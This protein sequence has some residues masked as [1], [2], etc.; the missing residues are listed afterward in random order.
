M[1]QPT[2][3]PVDPS[4][5]RE[6][7]PPRRGRIGWIVACSLG[8]GVVAALLLVLVV[9]PGAPEHVVTGGTLLGFGAGWALLA[10]LSQRWSDQPQRWALVPAGTLGVSGA[11]LLLLAPGARGM[12]ALGWG[13][14][15]VL[16]GLAV[17]VLV[18]ARRSLA[19]RTR[20]WLVYPVCAVTALAAVAGIVETVRS[21]AAP[22]MPAAGRTYDVAG[23]QLYLECSG[24][25]SPTVVLSSGFGQ[26]SPGWAW[27]APAVAQDT[28][29]CTHD[30]AGTGWSDP[31]G[32]PQDGVEV[33]AD[34]HML[35]AAAGV[36]GPYVL[37]GHS[38]GGVHDLV[39]ADRYP[40]DVAGMVLLDSS[41]P[42]QFALPG[43]ADSYGTWR[44]ASAL[45]PPLARLGLGRAAFGT[46]FG[47]LPP[48][49]R[50]RERALASS[51]RDLRGQRDEWSRLPDVFAQAQALTGLGDEPL[52]VLTAGRGLD[53]HW[54]A[55]QER[56][57]A[58]SDDS[59]HRVLDDAS[60][61][62]L[63]HDRETATADSAQAIRDVV[64]AVRSGAPLR[65]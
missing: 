33:A 16:L 1:A 48:D 7:R 42:E 53:P 56:L 24:T 45:L 40:S 5:R 6:V 59:V 62:S 10:L 41:T 4:P 34:L 32:H 15:P 18:Q 65:P 2:A 37:V 9:A 57:A 52:V 20:A 39:F 28:R 64:A 54:A 60:H 38:I 22:G 43:Y 51:A 44:R 19:S 47:E 29:V 25:G 58:L 30:R 27:V 31:A 50:D 36:P 14:P 46:G 13:W 23:R 8:A 3:T 49:A 17:W 35:L 11:A 26:H 55:A 63:L 12:A 21:T 61:M